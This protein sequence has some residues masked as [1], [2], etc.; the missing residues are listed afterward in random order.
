MI[1]FEPDRA[2]AFKKTVQWTVFSEGRE[3]L[4]EQGQIATQYASCHPD[5]LNL[6]NQAV[7][8][9]FALFENSYF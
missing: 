8:E 2:R 7:S 1:G 9:V 4:A 6:S 5:H 3:A